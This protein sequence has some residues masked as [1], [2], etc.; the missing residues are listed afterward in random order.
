MTRVLIVTDGLG[1]GGAERQLA[2]LA[3]S[4]PEPWT[5]SVL[6]MEDGPHRPVLQ[7]LG[8]DVSCVLRRHRFDVATAVR[9]WRASDGFAPDIVHSWGWMSTLAMLPFCR[10]RRIPLLNGTIRR[11]YLPEK[12]TR[13]ERLGIS[14]SDAVVA[15]SHAGLA[16]YGIAEGDRGR[17]VYNGFDPD[18]LKTVAGDVAP[19]KDT[20]VIMAARMAPAK[21]WRSFLGAARALA[22]DAPRWRFVAVGDG[23]GRHELETEAADLVAAGSFDVRDGGLE[24]LP[25]IATADIGVLLTASPEYAEGC[26]NS[27]LEY[28][29]CGLPV[30]CTDSGGNPELVE[31]GVT[32]SLVPPRDVAALVAALRRMRD[33]PA[34]AHRMGSEGKRRLETRFTVEAMVAGFIAAYAAALDA[35]REVRS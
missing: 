28:M 26:S 33:D 34:R 22:D 12:R 1:N 14:L 35:R 11:A 9:M 27:I 2:L 23:P 5:V 32:G 19:H 29:A 13:M 3:A 7:G 30:V 31:G 24:A 25:L 6:S 16:V 20:V 18:R 10:V 21:D 17:V 8:V 15:N 4:L